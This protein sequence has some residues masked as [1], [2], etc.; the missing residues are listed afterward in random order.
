MESLRSVLALRA[1]D[2][3]RLWRW[4]EEITEPS[5]SGISDPTAGYGAVYGG[6]GAG[7]GLGALRARDG[8]LLWRALPGT[9]VATP[10]LQQE[11][12]GRDLSCRVLWERSPRWRR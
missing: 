1:R 4:Q 5:S 8:Q 9:H 3:S 12:V 11:S 7:R 10:A 6:L 2:G